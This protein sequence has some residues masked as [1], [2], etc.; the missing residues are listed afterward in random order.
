[1]REIDLQMITIPDVSF[2]LF[3]LRPF[4]H[5]VAVLGTAQVCDYIKG[6]TQRNKKVDFFAAYPCR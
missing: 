3:R 2:T 4:P 1:M 5:S 6:F